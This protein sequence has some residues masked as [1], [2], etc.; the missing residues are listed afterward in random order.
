[1]NEM[2]F[3]VWCKDKQEW[4]KDLV[5]LSQDGYQYHASSYVASRYGTLIAVKPDNHIIYWAIGQRD[6]NGIEI[7]SGHIL[8]ITEDIL[9][10]VIY[11]RDGFKLKT[12]CPQ[13][14]VISRCYSWNFYEIIGHVCENPELLAVK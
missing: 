8:K 1:M 4:E 12:I 10:E 2:K 3:K 13:S 11:D 5:Y 7:Y 6:K 14:E 9:A